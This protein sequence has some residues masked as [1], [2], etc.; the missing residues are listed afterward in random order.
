MSVTPAGRE[1]ILQRIREA[2]RKRADTRHPGP[3]QSGR[4]SEQAGDARRQRIGAFVTAFEQA[5]GSV[6]HATSEEAAFGAVAELVDGPTVSY[7]VGVPEPF[8]ALL[9]RDDLRMVDAADATTAVSMARGAVA[10][11]GSLIMDARDGRR[12]QLL[13]PRH[14]ILLRA[15]DVYSTLRDGLTAIE[16]DLPSAVGLHSGPSKSADIGKIMVKGVHGPG[17]II[18]LLLDYEAQT[19]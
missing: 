14:V 11:T 4:L 8:R 1:A 19:G 15:A 3:F 12:P 18:A 6:R 13:S 5:G 9:E 2:N 10:E 7:G 16:G 17:E